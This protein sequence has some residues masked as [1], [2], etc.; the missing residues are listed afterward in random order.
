M[1]VQFNSNAHIVNQYRFCC[2]DAIELYED[3]FGLEVYHTLIRRTI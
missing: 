3:T 1:I 2:P